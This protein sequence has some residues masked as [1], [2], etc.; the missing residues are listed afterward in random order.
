MNDELNVNMNDELSVINDDKLNLINDKL[1]PALIPFSI[2]RIAADFFKFLFL[3]KY[4]LFVLR[5]FKK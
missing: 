1:H 5:K 3:L 4:F 2:V